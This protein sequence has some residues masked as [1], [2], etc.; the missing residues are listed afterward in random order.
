MNPLL[1]SSIFQIGEK[2]IEHFFPDP[3]KQAEAKLELLKLQESGDLQR[4]AQ[5]TDLAKA[6]IAL[7]TA[8][9]QSGSLLGKWRG[10]LGW[11][12]AGSLAYQLIIF[13]FM[14]AGILLVSPTF[15]VDKLPRLDWKTLGS[16]LMGMLGI[17]G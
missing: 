5:M 15:P 6:Q 10:A 4:L 2:L 17:G 8:E 3:Q 7:D 9:V 1:L 16:V 11:V 12:L 14:V 13:P